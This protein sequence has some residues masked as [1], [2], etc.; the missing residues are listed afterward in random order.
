MAMLWSAALYSPEVMSH[1]GWRDPWGLD[2]SLRAPAMSQALYTSLKTHMLEHHW[3][4]NARVDC[5]TGMPEGSL[6]PYHGCQ[7]YFFNHS[8]ESSPAALFYDGHVEMIGVAEAE[9]ADG[10]L[11]AQ[12]G[13]GIWSQDT[14]FGADGY[15]I[16][17]GYDLAATS[18]HVLTTDGIR[19]RDILSD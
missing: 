6:R 19:G 2:G 8:R 1:E 14:P 9:R 10:R 5:N 4:Q 13:W 15:F 16:E 12:S 7:P 3:L 17:Y 11:K 18:F